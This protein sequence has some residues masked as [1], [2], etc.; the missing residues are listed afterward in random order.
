MPW[1]AATIRIAAIKRRQLSKT[2]LWDNR[3]LLPDKCSCLFLNQETLVLRQCP[4]L[5]T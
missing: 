4:I 1:N 3:S 5:I 2:V